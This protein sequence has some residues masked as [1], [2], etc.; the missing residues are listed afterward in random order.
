MKKYGGEVDILPLAGSK[1]PPSE[2]NEHFINTFGYRTALVYISKAYKKGLTSE[3][4][5]GLIENLE[6]ST[7]FHVCVLFRA[8]PMA[9]GASLARGPTG[10]AATSLCRGHRKAR[11]EPHL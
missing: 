4:I 9:Y 2:M 10:A 11:S 6:P 8:A 1:L 7:F 3:N 5:S